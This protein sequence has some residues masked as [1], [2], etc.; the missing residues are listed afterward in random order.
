MNADMTDLLDGERP[1]RL[2]SVKWPSDL[3]VLVLAPHPDDFDAIGVTLRILRDNGNPIHV[4]VVC[5]S[6]SGVQDEFCSPPTAKV[7]A[8]IR[9]REQEDSCRFFGLPPSQLTFLRLEEDEAGH[10]AETEANL[11]RLTQCVLDR[12]PNLVFLPHGNDTNLGH[13]RTY[14]M[15]RR[16]ASEAG[17]PIAA[18]LN[19]DPKTI[20]MRHDAY[21]VFG[22]EEAE[23]KAKLLR[24]HCSQHQRN[25]NTRGHG[26]DERILRVD[27]EN[28]GKHLETD[29]H[30]E[31]FEIEFFGQEEE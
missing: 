28:A 23:W 21:T 17:C 11:E 19:R 7:K 15:F 9:E 3:R 31:I 10:L 30:A 24:C 14:A 12:C 29:G 13:Q 6:A 5:S 18:F 2:D 1:L 16:I 27:R 20:D 4:V 22:D 25:L 8:A 26:F